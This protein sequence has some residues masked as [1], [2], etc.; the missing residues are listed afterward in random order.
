MDRFPTFANM[1]RDP[2]ECQDPRFFFEGMR[3]DAAKKGLNYFLTCFDA[4]VGAMR[5]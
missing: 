1:A 2:R 3:F 5:Q 4:V